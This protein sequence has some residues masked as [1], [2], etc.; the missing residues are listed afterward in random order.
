[1]REEILAARALVLPSFAEGLPVVIMEAMALRRPVI[2][3][4]VAGIAELVRSGED[5]WL[6]PPGDVE[7]LQGA[8]EECLA[9][10]DR[11]H[12][13]DGREWPRA[14]TLEAFGRLR[15]CKA[16]ATVRAGGTSRACGPVAMTV[17]ILAG[18]FTAAALLLIVPVAVFLAQVV[19]ARG[20]AA[21]EV[22][23]ASVGSLAVLM[24]A[25][26]EAVGISAAIRAL[27][28]Q[29]RHTDR[30]LVVADNC[31]DDTAA[32]ALA[33]GA[34]VTVRV[35][36]VLRGKGYALDHGDPSPCGNATG[37]GGDRRC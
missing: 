1:M 13:A 11:G 9:A 16:G 21:V 20:K 12:R 15:S 24:P 26:D 31:S 6:V 19:A 7:A 5:G 32:V 30:L 28:P 27:V 22:T 33:S 29:L 2:S 25:H 34:E 3:T 4:F 36:P 23:G 37:C 35:D 14:R 18:I 10:P 8:I 17:A